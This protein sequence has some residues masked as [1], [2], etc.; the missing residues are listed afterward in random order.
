MLVGRDGGVFTFGDAIFRGSASN[1]HLN[2]P[3][4]GITTS[5]TGTGYRLVSRDGGVFGYGKVVF[6]GSLPEAPRTCQRRGRHRGH[7]DRQ[8]L[9]DRARNGRVYAFR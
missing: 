4:V 5:P 1:L 3:V 2:Q 7:A 9:L 6:A 8:G